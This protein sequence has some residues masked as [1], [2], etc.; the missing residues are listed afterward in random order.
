[1][2]NFNNEAI[3]LENAN[4]DA[5]LPKYTKFDS[6]KQAPQLSPRAALPA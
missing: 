4:P 1:M 3:S 2:A 6:S 5:P